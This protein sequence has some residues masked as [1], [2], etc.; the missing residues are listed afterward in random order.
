MDIEG[1]E[2]DVLET[3]FED[4]EVQIDQILVEFHDRMFEAEIPMSI[5][6]V[7]FLKEKGYAIFGAS[8]SSE[9]ISFIHHSVL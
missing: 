9:E 3:I 5:K 8:I 4:P 6:S 2:Y 1:A 7:E